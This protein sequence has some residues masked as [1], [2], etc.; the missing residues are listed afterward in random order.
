MHHFVQRIDDRVDLLLDRLFK[1]ERVGSKV[2]FG[3]S[4]GLHGVYPP[5]QDQR[6]RA[7]LGTCFR[8]NISYEFLVS[9]KTLTLRTLQTSFGRKVSVANY[10]IS[11]HNVISYSLQQETFTASVLAHYKS[12]RSAAV[13]D[14][15]NIVQQSVDL[16][17]PADRDV[18]QTYSRHNAAFE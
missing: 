3:G 5:V 8:G 2:A 16:V 1:L 11:V 10:E 7:A 17:F 6:Q 14:Y 9:G 12:E 15:V 4:F 18:W 13:R